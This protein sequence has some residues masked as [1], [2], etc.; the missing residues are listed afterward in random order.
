MRCRNICSTVSP[1]PD[2][3][4]AVGSMKA[5]F[6]EYSDLFLRT[7]LEAFDMSVE[8]AVD[9]VFA[10]NL[11][12]SL[13]NMDRRAVSIWQGKAATDRSFVLT[14]HDG[15][16]SEQQRAVELNKEKIRCAVCRNL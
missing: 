9:A 7:C 11:P 15:S 10:E 16:K 5:I 14:K 8:R 2:I 4:E 12:P 1:A 6:P 3:S 13:Q